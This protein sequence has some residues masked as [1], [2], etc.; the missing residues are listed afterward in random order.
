MLGVAVQ[1]SQTANQ[2]D[3]VGSLMLRDTEPEL[4]EFNRLLLRKS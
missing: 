4:N 3:E 1:P 2:T